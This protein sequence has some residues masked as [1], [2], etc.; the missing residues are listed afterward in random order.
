MHSNR[1]KD[2]N[3]KIC[4]SLCKFSHLP[5]VKRNSEMSM[6]I[7]D[8]LVVFCILFPEAEI[9]S[10]AGALSA[11]HMAGLIGNDKACVLL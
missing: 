9:L 11:L 8:V 4:G 7:G 6:S 2:R 3:V 5:A 1:A 10:S